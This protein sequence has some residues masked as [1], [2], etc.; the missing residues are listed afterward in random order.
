MKL[1]EGDVE[2]LKRVR[3]SLASAK[4]RDFICIEIMDYTTRA[5][6]EELSL[7]KNRLMFW[8][9]YAICD[10]WNERRRRL[11]TAISFGLRMYPTMGE[12]LHAE[13]RHKDIRFPAN[14]RN[15]T[16]YTLARIA[17]LDKIIETG[18]IQ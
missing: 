14:M 13:T 8:R 6:Q 5:K 4:S 16:L 9:R 2:L 7:W 10:R 18:K 11:L 1:V 17:W 12:W 15:S 3:D